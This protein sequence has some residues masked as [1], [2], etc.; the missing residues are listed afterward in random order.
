MSSR[1]EQSG[2]QGAVSDVTPKVKVRTFLKDM[3][4]AAELIEEALKLHGHDADLCAQYCAPRSTKQTPSA[5][6]EEIIAQQ[7]RDQGWTEDGIKT[8]V[9]HVKQRH[10]GKVSL[11]DCISYLRPC[12]SFFKRSG[13]PPR[14]TEG[15]SAP[16]VQSSSQLPQAL[17]T[18]PAPM[19]YQ[20]LAKRTLLCEGTPVDPTHQSVF[21]QPSLSRQDFVMQTQSFVAS[22]KS[23]SVEEV[24]TC[25]SRLGLQ[26]ALHLCHPSF[27]AED[28]Y[29][30]AVARASIRANVLV[31][32]AEAGWNLCPQ[33][34][35]LWKGDRGDGLVA[36]EN[37]LMTFTLAEHPCRNLS[38]LPLAFPAAYSESVAIYLASRDA[39]APNGSKLESEVLGRIR[40]LCDTDAT[41]KQM[42]LYADSPS[43]VGSDFY[44]KQV[45]KMLSEA[46]YMKS[47]PAY[48][49]ELKHFAAAESR[50]RHRG[51]CVCSA[52]LVIQSKILY[53]QGKIHV[54][55]P[56]ALQ[57]DIDKLICVA[58][59]A[60]PRIGELVSLMF[61]KPPYMLPSARSEAV[62]IQAF[63]QD[64]CSLIE[65]DQVCL[66]VLCNWLLARQPI[67]IFF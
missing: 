47:L 29:M 26:A 11:Q 1:G 13:T 50:R 30:V 66:Q 46:T 55:S 40:Q 15:P 8:A 3:G 38:M 21:A 7:L 61:E 20:E 31:P 44:G 53:L 9:Y 37:Q 6:T 12:S 45:I 33:F 58:I 19:S 41:F 52:H 48:R 62:E 43:L 28:D 36:S 27:A 65:D 14:A 22:C 17:H 39:E 59:A 23:N 4:Y 24:Y 2:A 54:E 51:L 63:L 49:P 60:H 42:L 18:S 56:N 5:A 57:P 32:L 25:H 34:D 10:N 64:L 67:L 16:E 35:A